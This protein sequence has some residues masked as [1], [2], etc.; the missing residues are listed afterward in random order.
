M[1][2]TQ[3]LI[4]RETSN[5]SQWECRVSSSMHR[6]AFG[7]RGWSWGYRLKRRC[8]IPWCWPRIPRSKDR[9]RR[10]LK[11]GFAC[12][13]FRRRRN[14]QGRLRRTSHGGRRERRAVMGPE[15]KTRNSWE[16]S[17]DRLCQGCLRAAGGG[18]WQRTM[19][20]ISEGGHWWLSQGQLWQRDGKRGGNCV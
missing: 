7:V 11:P 15:A 3:Q 2:V 13:Q 18:T 16:G 1:K 19:G 8:L 17:S 9:L 6:S 5:A 14:Q 10:S 12:L 20:Q 4:I